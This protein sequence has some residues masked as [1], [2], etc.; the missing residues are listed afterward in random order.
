LKLGGIALK[1][2]GF[3]LKIEGFALRI[4]EFALKMSVLLW[5][6]KQWA[7]TDIKVLDFLRYINK[8]LTFLAVLPCS[9]KIWR[10]LM[11]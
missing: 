9:I 1:I 5:G 8:I 7:A 3:A 10:F 6:W 4:E 2:E 11:E